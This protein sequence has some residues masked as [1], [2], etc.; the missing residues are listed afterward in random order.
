MNPGMFSSDVDTAHNA[1]FPS[2][3]VVF[4]PDGGP[5]TVGTIERDVVAPAS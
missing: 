3:V 2:A 4:T 1:P 5:P